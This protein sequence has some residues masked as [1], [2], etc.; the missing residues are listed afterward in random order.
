MQGGPWM[1]DKHLWWVSDRPHRQLLET[2]FSNSRCI[3]VEETYQKHWNDNPEPKWSHR[4][5]FGPMLPQSRTLRGGLP[6][7]LPKRSWNQQRIQKSGNIRRARLL[8]FLLT[9]LRNC[10]L[11]STLLQGY[12]GIPF[13]GLE[14]RPAHGKLW[15]CNT[16]WETNIAIEN[17][18]L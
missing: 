7:F 6:S 16:L 14:E 10:H 3:G 4:D 11:F 15:I 17:G 18:H 5:F 2:S 1:W 13:S 12:L 9:L 8:S